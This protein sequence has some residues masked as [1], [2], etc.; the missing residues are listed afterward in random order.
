MEQEFDFTARDF[1]N[2]SNHDRFGASTRRFAASLF[3]LRDL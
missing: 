2:V 1:F 3:W